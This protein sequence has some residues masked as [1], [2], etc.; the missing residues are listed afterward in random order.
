MDWLWLSPKVF[1][2]S[3]TLWNPEHHQHLMGPTF[4]HDQHFLKTLLRSIHIFS[5]SK[6]NKEMPP[7]VSNS[8]YNALVLYKRMVE[9]QQHHLP[10]RGKQAGGNAIKAGTDRPHADDQNISEFGI[11]SFKKPSQVALVTNKSTIFC[12]QHRPA[13]IKLELITI[14]LL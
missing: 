4:A 2:R 6:T 10:A 13:S 5:S 11:F 3:K 1:G 12:S 9:V 14:I 7:H 8:C